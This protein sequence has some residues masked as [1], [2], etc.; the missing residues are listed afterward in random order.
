MQRVRSKD[1]EER[2]DKKKGA[3]KYLD[4]EAGEGTSNAEPPSYILPSD[5]AVT[6]RVRCEKRMRFL[7]SQCSYV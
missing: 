4:T 1:D 2:N 7:I 5:A 6:T 3:S